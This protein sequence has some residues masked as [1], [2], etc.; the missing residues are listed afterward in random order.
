MAT[1]KM[2]IAA[3]QRLSSS[4]TGHAPL[5]ILD[6]GAA[7]P[8][9]P[10]LLFDA[11]TDEEAHFLLDVSLYGSGNITVKV[12]YSMASAT[13]GDV[14]W[15]AQLMAQTPDDAVDLV[16]ATWDTANTVTDTVPGTAGHMTEAT[17]TLSNL[18]SLAAGDYA[19]LKIYRDANAAGDTATGDAE[20]IQLQIEFSDT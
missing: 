3:D 7:D 13:S 15:A 20:L 17:I 11:A 16:T 14:I 9:I 19:I 8:Q 1:V 18:D 6:G 5:S 12:R 4:R 10:V 2:Q